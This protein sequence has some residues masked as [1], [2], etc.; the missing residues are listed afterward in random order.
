VKLAE[1]LVQ[2]KALKDKMERLRQR[3][4]D[5]ARVQESDQPSEDPVALLRET[6]TVLA[7]LEALMVRINRTNL[8]TAMPDGQGTLMEAI[9]H[10][11]MLNLKRSILGALVEAAGVPRERW[12]V[13]RSEIRF[14]ST[15]DVAQMQKE[16]DALAK[17]HREL[18]TQVQAVNWLVE[19]V[20]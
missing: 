2:R 14:R 3:L 16:I 7:E 18:D 13:T 5:N 1:A 6:D 9:A 17:A 19:L 15:V 4:R 12:A 11:D 10:R 8:A 20:D